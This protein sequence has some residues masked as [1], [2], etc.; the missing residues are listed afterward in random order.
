MNLKERVNGLYAETAV[1]MQHKSESNSCRFPYFQF[2]F[3]CFFFDTVQVGFGI[4]I[5]DLNTV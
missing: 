1:I 3:S 2:C 5:T 4:F